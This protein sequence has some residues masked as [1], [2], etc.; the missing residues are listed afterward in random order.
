MVRRSLQSILGFR[1]WPF[2]LPLIKVQCLLI[3]FGLLQLR[4]R[5]AFSPW[6]FLRVFFTHAP[7]QAGRVRTGSTLAWFGCVPALRS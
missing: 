1:R 6:P 2:W 3:L 5:A 4:I 7:A